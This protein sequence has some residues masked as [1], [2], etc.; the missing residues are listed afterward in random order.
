MQV[1]REK[2]RSSAKNVPQSRSE[3]VSVARNIRVELS[4]K[5]LLMLNN[6]RHS[7]GALPEKIG[8]S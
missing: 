3:G 4:R 2:L 1:E 6:R 7:E 8:I 5:V